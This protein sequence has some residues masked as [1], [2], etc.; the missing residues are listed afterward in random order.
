MFVRDDIANKFFQNTANKIKENFN[1]GQ[2]SLVHITMQKLRYG[3]KHHWM[4]SIA[5]KIFALSPNLL[6]DMLFDNSRHTY[7]KF[8]CRRFTNHR[9][10]LYNVCR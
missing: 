6:A 3:V 10:L 4:S 8:M 9:L 7:F 1:L 2:K 5:P